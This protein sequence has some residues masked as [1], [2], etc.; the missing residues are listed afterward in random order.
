[1][2]EKIIPITAEEHITNFKKLSE[3]L[4]CFV[5][6]TTSG[7]LPENLILQEAIDQSVKYNGFF[8]RESVLYSLTAIA[9][10]LADGKLNQWAGAYPRLAGNIKT[11]KKIAV[12]MAG[13]IPL[14]GFHDFLCVLIS[15][16]IF[17]GKL[18][19]NDCFLLPAIAQILIENDPR[20]R[21]LIC[22]TEDKLQG[23]DAVI[24]TGSNNTSRY[25]EYYFEKYPHIIRRHRNSLAVLSGN[26][27][28]EQLHLLGGDIFNYFGMGCRNV[29]GLFVPPNYDFAQFVS[30]MHSFAGIN[31]HNK[32]RNNYDYYKTIFII[33][34]QPFVD[35]GF[36][37][38]K[39]DSSI[40]SPVAVIHFQQYNSLSEVR[41]FI[42]KNKDNI[43]CVVGG[44]F[45]GIHTIDFG[46]AQS[47]EL[48]DYADN[49]DTMEFLYNL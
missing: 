22:F 14:V 13:N 33:N 39:E 8:T 10:M 32:Y 16:N 26:E 17:I 34:N 46:K 23:F 1:M 44:L 12:V 30:G 4:N 35:G 41:S 21:E 29:T 15:G 19:K 42:D 28:P 25:F 6:R 9:G 7:D 49:V 27:T 18:S 47:P 43:Q 45:D 37:I 2:D 40:N 20:Y 38:L 36:F 31:D 24:A 5:Q 3:V 11:P 48:W